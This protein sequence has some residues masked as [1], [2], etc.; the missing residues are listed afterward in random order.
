MSTGRTRGRG[1]G[2]GLAA[3]NSRTNGAPTGPSAARGGKINGATRPTS[4]ATR[5]GF[6]QNGRGN[7][8][9]MGKTNATRQASKNG[10]AGSGASTTSGNVEERYTAVSH[11]TP[12]DD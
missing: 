8:F 4:N 6:A 3:P 2:G 5:G 7:P 1:R 10:S 11:P 12:K 9:Q